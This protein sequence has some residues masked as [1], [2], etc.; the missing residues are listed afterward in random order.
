MDGNTLNKE[1]Y[2]RNMNLAT[3]VYINQINE[4]SCGDKVIHLYRGADSSEQLTIRAYLLQ[5]LKGSKQQIKEL[6]EKPNYFEQAVYN[7]WTGLLD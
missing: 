2:E 7:R 3:D 4:C 6:K 5:Y 1:K